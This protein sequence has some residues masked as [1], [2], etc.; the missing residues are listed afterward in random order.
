MK[1]LKK[2]I[3]VPFIGVAALAV[4]AFLPA[5]LYGA[6]TAG[7]LL[8]AL[9]TWQKPDLLISSLGYDDWKETA[10]MISFF[11]IGFFGIGIMWLLT[12]PSD[13]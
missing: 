11:T 6:L 10:E 5:C 8:T 9:L 13:E 2:L 4:A 7:Q 12:L 3:A 1:V